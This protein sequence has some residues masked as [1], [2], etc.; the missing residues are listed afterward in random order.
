M[1]LWLGYK[2]ESYKFFTCSFLYVAI[3]RGK[4]ETKSISIKN[5]KNKKKN[6]LIFL[7]KKKKK[8]CFNWINKFSID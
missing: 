5:L 4:L 7:I 2:N 6:R 8:N 3:I 1:R